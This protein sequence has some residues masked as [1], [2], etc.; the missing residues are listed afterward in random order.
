MLSFVIIA[1]LAGMLAVLF[2]KDKFTLFI[3]AAVAASILALLYNFYILYPN[4]YQLSYP[5]LKQLGFEISIEI[6]F[7]KNNLLLISSVSVLSLVALLTAMVTPSERAKNNFAAMLIFNLLSIIFLVSSQNYIQLI[8]F[9]G[10]IDIIA[11]TLIN[12]VGAKKRFVYS[13]FIADMGLVSVFALII[14]QTASVDIASTNLPQLAHKDYIVIVTLVCLFIKSG[15]FFFHN[16]LGEL[17]SLSFNRLSF[18]LFA[19]SPLAS[20]IVLLK[21]QPMLAQ[22][23]CYTD[24][25]QIFSI[26][27]I[28]FG[29]YGA[30]VIDNIKRKA[31]YFA[32]SFWGIAYALSG[33]SY[34][35]IAYFLLGA[36]LFS[37]T[38]LIA[39][40]ASSNVVF[41]SEMGSFAKSLKFVFALT[42]L[43]SASYLAFVYN[44]QNGYALLYGVLFM[45]ASSQ[46]IAQIYFGCNHADCR[47]WAKLHTPSFL[48]WTPVLL[49]AVFGGYL[50]FQST[51][52]VF[53]GFAFLLLARPLRFLD[54]LYQK[55]IIQDTSF[56]TYFWELI[57]ILPLKIVGRILW[58]TVDFMFIEKT[59]I[60]SVGSSFE[61]GIRVFNKLHSH[62][63]AGYIVSILLAVILAC[64]TWA[65]RGV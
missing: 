36:F 53:V 17:S 23:S 1:F 20:F 22:S 63:V 25:L 9:L 19:S 51:W 6:V 40:E 5:W 62:K 13:N 54:R 7:L 11:F 56:F 16:G 46:V 41:V 3:F 65:F 55:T 48:I 49:L 39:N 35:D 42:A 37:Q 8:I 4:K 33:F 10:I 59:I 12:D 21:L 26:L 61:W 38:L 47:V 44:L 24:L 43:F 29:A 15:L 52:F 18:I 31:V 32:L 60:S 50:Y 45:L 64:L 14:G 28:V 34:D 58:L 30:L 2:P 27:S 57:L